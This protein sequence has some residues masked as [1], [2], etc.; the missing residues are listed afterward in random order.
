MFRRLLLKKD[1]SLLLSGAFD[2]STGLRRALSTFELVSLGVGGIIG[3][4][5]F[6]LTGHAAAEFAGPAVTLS[7]LLALVACGFAGFCYAELASM[8]P[9]AGSAYTYAYASMG[10][11]VAWIIG[12]DL[13]LEYF[14][15][16]TTV[17]IGWS[18]Y[19]VSFLKDFGIYFPEKLSGPLI[20]YNTDLHSWHLTG[21][22]FNLPALAILFI[23]T[24][25]LI[26][27][28]RVS[29]RANTAIVVLKVTILLV[30]ITT[31]V[32]YIKPE[33]WHPFIPPNTGTFGSFGVSGVFRAAGFIFFAYIGFDSVSTAASE[34][35]NP[36]KSLPVGILGSLAICT[37][38]YLVVSLI[39]TGVVHYSKLGGA[40]PIATA[41]D[42]MGLTFLSPLI[43]IGAIAGLTSVILVLALGQT[44]IFY[45]MSK[46]NL[47]P[48]MFSRIHKRYRTPHVSTMVVG[49]AASLAATLLPI[50][51]VSELVSI[52]TLLAFLIVCAGVLILKYTRPDIKR[53]FMVPWGPVIPIG[54]IISCLYLMAGLPLGTWFR[55]I[56][57]LILGLIVYFA[58]SIKK[59]SLNKIA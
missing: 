51:I 14:L 12:W 44:R 26:V 47:L 5:I 22:I 54:G 8:M 23:V 20:S 24:T 10:E 33:L 36:Q 38:L 40:A 57:W 30:F 3:A 11:F 48:P 34:A 50:D 17:A 52:G 4:G 46:D 58:Y 25:I 35:K 19:V 29:S 16:A 55:L 37:V 53:T 18:G 2:E 42:A 9:I 6:V 59:S 1:I 31:G 45:A 13:I 32:F 28:I 41:T 56:I 43:K 7:F 15:G 27:G 39:M 21:N 49:A